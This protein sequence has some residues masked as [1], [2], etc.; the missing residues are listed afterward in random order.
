MRTVTTPTMSSFVDVQETE[1]DDW[2]D[3]TTKEE[4]LQREVDALKRAL[5]EK[6]MEL[7]ESNVTV[8]VLKGYKLLLE[9]EGS[10]LQRELTSQAETFSSV[11]ED[12]QSSRKRETSLKTDLDAAKEASKHEAKEM[13]DSI[14]QKNSDLGAAKEKISALT[15]LMTDVE[16]TRQEESSDARMKIE[17]L[18]GLVNQ[19]QGQVASMENTIQ[20]Q[21]SSLVEYKHKLQESRKREQTLKVQ[22]AHENTVCEQLQQEVKTFKSDAGTIAIMA[23][24]LRAEK[25]ALER[26]LSK[27]Q[28]ALNLSQKE[29]HESRVHENK[30]QTELAQTKI[31]SE[32]RIMDLEQSLS[33]N[34][35]DLD[36]AHGL[37]TALSESLD[38]MK[39]QMGMVKRSLE[40]ECE[41]TRRLREEQEHFAVEIARKEKEHEAQEEHMREDLLTV[42]HATERRL[43]ELRQILGVRPDYVAPKFS[44]GRYQPPILSTVMSFV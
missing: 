23:V 6:T 18:A 29:I 4:L 5:E 1:Q 24:N 35:C 34:A 11:R 8:D 33:S 43:D 40:V 32:R 17:H 2:L 19:F 15:K 44:F 36:D 38:D 7:T 22:V 14:H 21:N 9:N 25:I 37:V 28:D 41:E 3:V 20:K 12:L 30:F 39:N 13:Q 16:N 42:R 27:N 10:D 26:T 31:A